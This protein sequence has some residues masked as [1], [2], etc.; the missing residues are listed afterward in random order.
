MRICS[1]DR[2]VVNAVILGRAELWPHMTSIYVFYLFLIWQTFRETIG[3]N[4]IEFQWV[5]VVCNAVCCPRRAA[6]PTPALRAAA[7]CR[8]QRRAHVDLATD[9]LKG[10]SLSRIFVA[11]LLAGAIT[12]GRA[13][14]SRCQ[15]VVAASPLDCTFWRLKSFYEFHFAVVRKFVA[16]HKLLAVV[17]HTTWRTI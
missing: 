2:K 6:R 16:F 12:R 13:R 10:Y 5:I 3:V 7:C 17:N 14:V 11:P 4:D 8:A 1:F 9:I 15:T